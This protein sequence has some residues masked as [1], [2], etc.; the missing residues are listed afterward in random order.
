MSVR[1]DFVMLGVREP[2]GSASIYAS[3]EL[4]HADLIAHREAPLAVMLSMD[5][6]RRIP[7]TRFEL[8]AV[9]GS[10]AEGHGASY[11]E[12]LLDLMRTWQPPD[13]QRALVEEIAAIGEASRV[14]PMVVQ[15]GG[16]HLGLVVDGEVVTAP[17]ALR[18]EDA[19]IK[20]V[21]WRGQLVFNGRGPVPPELITVTPE[22]A[23]AGRLFTFDVRPMTTAERG[24]RCPDP[25]REVDPSCPAHGHSPADA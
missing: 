16:S 21:D 5:D 25:L 14:E 1:P 4:R 11:A 8:E 15:R 23:A 12:A 9:L 7:P 6:P 10:Y 20:V 19:W 24:C 2:D 22:D 17:D 18:D 3:T 13:A